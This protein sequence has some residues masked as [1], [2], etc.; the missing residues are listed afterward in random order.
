MV[1]GQGLPHRP[2]GVQGVALGP[3]APRWS[4]GPADL[5]H[6]LPVGLQERRQPGAVAAGT[7]N[8]PAASTGHLRPGEVE[9]ATVAGRIC[10]YRGLGDQA[11]HRVGGGSERVPVGVDADH[12]VDGAGQPA[13]PRSSFLLVGLVVPAWRTPRGA[14][15]MGHDP[16]RVD[17]LLISPARR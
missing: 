16:G 2:D 4:L 10:P 1:L 13:H 11:T 6:P 12:A 3:A 9:Q 17:R 14:S 15:V 8:R 5:D 7:L